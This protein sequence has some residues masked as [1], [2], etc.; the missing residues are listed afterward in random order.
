MAAL[1]T[2]SKCGVPPRMTTPR[3]TTASN[4]ADS[5]HACAT[6]G[7]SNDPGTRTTVASALASPH[8]RAA[9]ASRPSIT[10]SCH[11]AA[12]MATRSAA[13]R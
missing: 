8:A 4:C 13:R 9:P 10:V 5:A 11:D 7:S 6:T 12:T 2:Y 3:Q 1:A